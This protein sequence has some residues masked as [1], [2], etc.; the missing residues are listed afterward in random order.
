MPRNPETQDLKRHPVNERSESG[1]GA[2]TRDSA[3]PAAPPPMILDRAPMPPVAFTCAGEERTGAAAAAESPKQQGR[4]REPGDEAAVSLACGRASAD[5][6]ASKGAIVALEGHKDSRGRV[7]RRSTLRV[8][9]RN[10]PLPKPTRGVRTA[11][12]SSDDTAAKTAKRETIM[13][14]MPLDESARASFPDDT[15]R[16][17]KPLVRAPREAVS[18]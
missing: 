18:C 4:I 6:V 14:G 3:G 13:I 7:P 12:D 5:G 15:A 9:P 16:T 2:D 11:R 8:P 17:G 10:I 1:I